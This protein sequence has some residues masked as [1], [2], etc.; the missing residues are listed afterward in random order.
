MHPEGRAIRPPREI[1]DLLAS[2]AAVAIGNARLFAESET[3]RR[4]AEAL[5]EVWRFLSE[6]FDVAALGQRIA[7]V[8][9]RALRVR[10][11]VLYRLLPGSGDLAVIG[12]SGEAERLLDAGFV[13]PAGHGVVGL[14]VNRR[15]PVVT[16][17]V[18]VD[19]CIAL[20]EGMRQS[21]ALCPS[22]LSL[23]LVV[24]GQVMGGFTVGDFPAA[25]TPT[26]IFDWPRPL[27]TR[28]R[29]R[30]RTRGSSRRRSGGV[31]RAW[32]SAM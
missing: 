2:H 6:T 18:R 27:P 28:R 22:V 4:T 1:V 7:D 26:K 32:R 3:R 30:S 9:L 15:Q 5:A 10:A 8:V 19:P 23:P 31:A 14:A 24:K 29:W 11:A 20:T 12:R 16:A 17:D 21:H 25:S 13:I